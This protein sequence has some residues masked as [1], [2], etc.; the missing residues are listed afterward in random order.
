MPDSATYVYCL[1]QSA[2]T[3]SVKG[4]PEGI[5]AGGPPRVLPVDRGIWAIVAD[6]PLER[7]SGEPFQQELQDIEAVSRYAL[8]HAGMIEAQ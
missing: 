7:F 3:P 5:P 2:R 1:V 6:A 4:A 8:A